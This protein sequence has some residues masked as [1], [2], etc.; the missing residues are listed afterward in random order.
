MYTFGIITAFAVKFWW[1][2][3]FIGL[4]YYVR[5]HITVVMPR[6]IR[7]KSRNNKFYDEVVY[8]RTFHKAGAIRFFMLWL[9]RISKPLFWF[10]SQFSHRTDSS[11]T[12]SNDL[13]SHY[14]EAI[15]LFFHRLN[16]GGSSSNKSTKNTQSECTKKSQEDLPKSK[17]F[18]S[19]DF[20]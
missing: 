5:K 2:I 10:K 1:V 20:M 15:E 16:A 3:A 18:R 13:I 17:K 9:I 6:T 7:K 4:F 8:V 11:K 12:N 19:G 14:K